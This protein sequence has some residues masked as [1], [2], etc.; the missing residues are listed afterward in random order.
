MAASA[1]AFYNSFKEFMAD[2]TI[3]LD[4]HNFWMSLHT[5]ASNAATN[6]LSTFASVTG[7]IPDGNGYSTSGKVLSGVTWGNGASVSEKRWD[8]T[9]RIWS[10]TGGNI[11]AIK[12]AVI[13]NSAGKLVCRSQLST[14]QFSVTT[15]NTLTITPSAN[16]IFELN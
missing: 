8:A 16:G 10:A 5:S 7:E 12:Y 1:W 14:A 4:T 6:T 3:D 15:G 9:A 2:G 13:R 11:S